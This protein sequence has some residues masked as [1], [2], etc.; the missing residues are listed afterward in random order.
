M[1]SKEQ[2][3]KI[4]YFNNLLKSNKLEYIVDSLTGLINRKYILDYVK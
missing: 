4:E 1:Y 3:M 2:L